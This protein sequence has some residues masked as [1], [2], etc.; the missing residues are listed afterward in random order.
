MMMVY[1]LL[2]IIVLGSFISGVVLMLKDNKAA[3]NN[4]EILYDDPK[5]LFDDSVVTNKEMDSLESIDTTVKTK[6]NENSADESFDDE[7]I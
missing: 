6:T 5:I 3:K 4:T 7:I 2:G 1:I